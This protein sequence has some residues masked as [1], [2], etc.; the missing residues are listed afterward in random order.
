MKTYAEVVRESF[1]GMTDDDLAERWHSADLTDEARQQLQA[2]LTSRGITADQVRRLYEAVKAEQ[3]G[4]A[5]QAAATDAMLASPLARLGAQSIDQIAALLIL[6]LSHPAMVQ[7]GMPSSL[8]G[9]VS[10]LAFLS[11][12]LLSDALPNGQTVGK[13][14]FRIATV[15]VESG[16]PCSWGRSL[17]RNLSLLLLSVFDVLSIFGRRRQRLGDRLARTAV[18]KL[19]SVGRPVQF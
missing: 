2:E 3:D 10:L 5:A 1:R 19:E 12:H 9:W 7:L 6:L 15:H 16:Q 13:F 8:S 11:Y 18:V 17:V 4:Q 14:I